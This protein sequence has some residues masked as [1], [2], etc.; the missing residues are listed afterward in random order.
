MTPQECRQRPCPRLCAAL[1]PRFPVALAFLAL[2]LVLGARAEVAPNSLFSDD[3]VLQR[4]VPVPIWGTATNEGSVTVRFGGQSVTSAVNHGTWKVW[5][6]PMPANDVPQNL[7][8]EGGKNCLIRNV[9]VGDVWVA[10]GQSNMG[11]QLGPRQWQPDIVGWR[12]AVDTADFPGIRQYR[13]PEHLAVAPVADAEG[14]WSVCSKSTAAEF[15]AVGFFFARS[16]HRAERVPIGILFSAWGGTVAE[17]WVSETSLV[18]MPDFRGA[19]RF[20]ENLRG[21]QDDDRN[22]PGVIYNAMI[23]PLQSFPIKGVIWY[24]GE[25]NCD[26]G[27]QYRELFPLL[28]KDWRKGWGMGDFP[29]LFVEIAPCKYWTPEI[30][31]AQLLTLSRTRNTAMIGTADIGDA[32]DM[33]PAQKAPVGERL[34]LAARALAYGERI[35]YSGPL[36]EGIKIDGNRAV[37]GFSHTGAGLVAKGGELRG[38]TMAGPDGVFAAA[39]AEIKGANVVVTSPGVG[40]PVAVRFGWARVPDENLFNADGLPASPFRTDDQGKPLTDEQ[41]AQQV[42]GLL[43]KMTVQEKTLQLL[44]YQSNGVPRLGISDLETCE[45]LHGVLSDGATC[46]PQAIAMGAMWDP[47]LMEQIAAVG[48]SEARALGLGQAFAPMLGLAR[49]PRWGR[50]EESYGEDPYL[51]SVNG[52]AYING[53]QG[54]GSNRFGPDRIIATAKHFVADGEPFAGENGEDLETSERVL[55][56][57]YLPPFEAAVREANVGCLMPAHHA[58][59]GIPCHANAWLLDE[60]ARKEWGFS[61]FMVSDMSDIP[62][63]YS[64]AEDWAHLY[65]TSPT[66]AAIRAFKAGVDVELVGDLYKGF[67]EAI[68][69]GQISME[70]LDRSVRRVL[71]LKV[72]L[73]GLSVAAARSGGTPDETKQAILGHAGP[74]DMFAKLIAEGKFTSPAGARKADYQDVLNFPTHDVLARRAAEEAI[75]LLKNKDNLLPLDP[76]T[77]KKILVVGPLAVRQNLGG[78]SA[79]HPKFYVNVVEGLRS[80]LGTGT[81]V[82]YEPGCSIENESTEALPAAVA[83]ASNADV[84]VAVVGQTRDQAGENLDRDSL[85]LVGGQERLVEAMQ[86][87]GKP[88]VAVLENGAPLTINWIN[89]HVPAIVESWYL[90][91]ACGSAVAEALLGKINPAGRLPV[92]F[93]RNVGQIPCYYNH[94]VFTG[95]MG[96]YKSP[97]VPLYPFGY[98]LSYTSFTYSA[99]TIEPPSAGLTGSGLSDPAGGAAATVSVTVSNTGKRAGDEVVQMY[100][101]QDFTSLKRPVKELKGFQRITLQP[102]ESS[103]VRF[104]L[105]WEQLKFWKDGAWVVEPGTVKVQVGASSQDIRTSGVLTL[106]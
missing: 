94:P 11:R 5:L 80:A 86:A 100:I 24:Q 27:R 43:S 55:R 14:S 36:F 95:P 33:H 19:N 59:N 30:R 56:E 45:M 18:A 60:V 54:R 61:G 76:A 3:C 51:V 79:G 72:R 65:A 82:N 46:F 105:G 17:S 13:V 90:G 89:E 77:L 57:V 28:I 101:R 91:Q 48:A 39:K 35:E 103:T 102:G 10:S 75:V 53:M 96:Y 9:L 42:D 85:D 41:L 4:D 97:Y 16:L 99:L 52:V 106:K 47:D 58:I 69:S 50:V 12:E 7:T 49:D 1:L 70:E 32:N 21:L 2:V 20:S 104:K 88:V 34:A 8:I 26:R 22:I 73:L 15:T 68:K 78:Y 6:K 38:F 23:A 44:A 25:S 92:S 71:M 93:P 29:F 98:G 84:I 74:E 40:T 67:P 37:I 81:L 63:L 83:A 62:K 87:T 64:L 66:D 31:E